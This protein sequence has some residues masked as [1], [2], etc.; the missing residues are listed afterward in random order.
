[1]E[2]KHSTTRRKYYLLGQKS[3]H[4][5]LRITFCFCYKNKQNVENQT[6]IFSHENQSKT[7][8]EK[9]SR[10]Y[11]LCDVGCSC[12]GDVFVSAPGLRE[13]VAFLTIKETRTLKRIACITTKQEHEET[14]KCLTGP[15]QINQ[16]SSQKKYCTAK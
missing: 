11:L 9:Q 7:F 2:N 8:S 1:M 15:L 10:K 13:S 4:L 12:V 16:T 3:V 6:R 5:F 14:T